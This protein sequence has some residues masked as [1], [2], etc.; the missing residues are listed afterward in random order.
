MTDYTLMYAVLIPVF[1]AIAI[2]AVILIV[3][4]IIEFVQLH[5]ANK[6]LGKWMREIEEEGKSPRQRRK[7]FKRLK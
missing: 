4:G 3:A 6:N 7:E 5:K 2:C 1:S